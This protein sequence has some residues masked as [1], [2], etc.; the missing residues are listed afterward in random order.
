MFISQQDDYKKTVSI[1]AERDEENEKSVKTKASTL[2][3]L[4]ISYR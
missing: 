4:I 3:K 2:I 1:L